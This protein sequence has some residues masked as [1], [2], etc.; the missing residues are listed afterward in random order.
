MPP[1]NHD[2]PPPDD[3][4][5]PEGHG[6]PGHADAV[7]P[8]PHGLPAPGDRLCSRPADALPDSPDPVPTHAYGL[9]PDS[10]PMSAASDHM[11]ATGPD[12]LSPSSH[13]VPVPHSLQA[14]IDA[15]PGDPVSL[16]RGPQC[17]AAAGRR[18]RRLTFDDLDLPIRAEC[19]GPASSLPPGPDA[20]RR[21]AGRR[22]DPISRLG[23]PMSSRTRVHTV[24]GAADL[25]PGTLH[26]LSGDTDRLPHRGDDLQPDRLPGKPDD[27]SGGT[28]TLSGYRNALSRA[29][30]T[31]SLRRHP[32][33]GTVVQLLGAPDVPPRDPWAL[34]TAA[35][36]RGAFS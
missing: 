10:D 14:G 17:S 19:P 12:P 3:E 21:P 22:T 13:H 28:G 26:V 15:L 6:V 1:G 4:M 16:P 31:L 27:L 24:S 11:H 20:G 9:P 29:A 34:S 25:V 30:D 36:R 33:P 5:P 18:R 23:N 7:P 8:D 32:L 35:A 2:L